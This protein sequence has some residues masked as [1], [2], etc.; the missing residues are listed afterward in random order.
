MGGSTITKVG[1]N[2]GDLLIQ[3]KEQIELGA[4]AGLFPDG[5]VFVM[6]PSTEVGFILMPIFLSEILPEV[7]FVPVKSGDIEMAVC[8]SKQFGPTPARGDW[9]AGVHLRT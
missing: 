7:A 2:I 6:N 4:K 9:I 1:N 3:I 8:V 5:D